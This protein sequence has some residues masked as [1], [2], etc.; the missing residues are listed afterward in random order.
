MIFRLSIVSGSP[1]IM[2]IHDEYFASSRSSIIVNFN[3]LIVYQPCN[4]LTEQKL[5]DKRIVIFSSLPLPRLFFIKYSLPMVHSNQLIIFSFFS[6]SEKPKMGGSEIKLL[7]KK[8]FLICY[9]QVIF[10]FC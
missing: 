5:N 2:N 4:G 9:H 10:V 3:I 6:S 8:D 7:S 1:F